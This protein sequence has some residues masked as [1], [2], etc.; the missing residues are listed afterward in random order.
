MNDRNHNALQLA[1]VS[2]VLASLKNVRN[3]S[4]ATML[5]RYVKTPLCNQIL[6][7]LD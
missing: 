5:V 6:G 2:F 7:S 1:I 4:Y 3:S